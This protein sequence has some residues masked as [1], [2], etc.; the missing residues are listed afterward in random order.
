MPRKELDPQTRSRLCEL[1][2]IGWSYRKIHSRYPHIPL[3]TIKTT[4]YRE[5]TRDNNTTRSR[6]G[7]PRRL[8]EEHRDRLWEI[9]ES[10]P[11][12]KMDDIL[13]EMGHIVKKRTVQNALKEM[14]KTRRPAFSTNRMQKTVA[15]SQGKGEGAV[16]P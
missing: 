8:T 5:H 2:S 9:V 4:V 11:H 13:E 14:G 15:E 10:N 6:T 12:I 1:R 3:S 7:H 16:Q